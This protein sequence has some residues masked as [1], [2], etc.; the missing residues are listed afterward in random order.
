MSNLRNW[1]DFLEGLIIDSTS[2][3]Q[4]HRFLPKNSSI[5]LRSGESSG[6]SISLTPCSEKIYCIRSDRWRETLSIT[7]RDF[8]LYACCGQHSA[9][10]DGVSSPLLIT[11]WM[12]SSVDWA[13]LDAILRWAT[14]YRLLHKCSCACIRR[15]EEVRRWSME[16]VG[17]YLRQVLVYI[18]W[19]SR[20]AINN[21]QTVRLWLHN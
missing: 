7:R 1:I 9:F 17:V 19:E 15:Y 6:K 18:A 4:L 13:R 16:V 2:Y 11:S 8:G 12:R 10:W 20:R 21:T 5:G 14:S 3:S